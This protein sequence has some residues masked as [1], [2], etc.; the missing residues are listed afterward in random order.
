M[1]DSLTRAMLLVHQG[2]YREAE[3]YLRQA[4]QDNP[5]DPQIFFYLATCLLHDPQR[6]PEALDSI[7]ESLRLFPNCGPYHAQKANILV[8]LGRP[9]EGLQEVREA[10]AQDPNS[11]DSYVSESVALL[12]LGH[13]K[14]AE[15]AA[16]RALVLDPD[17]E[18][19]ADNLADAL[20]IQ[21]RFSESQQ[22][23][24]RLLSR[25]PEN[26]WT[27]A[28]AG[29][30]DLQ[31]GNRDA[32]ERHFLESLRLEP[33][34]AGAKEGLIN[35]FRSRSPLYR[36]Y[37]QYSFFMQRLSRRGRLF[38]IL[39][40]LFSIQVARTAASGTP[41][42][43]IGLLVVL[44]YLLVILWIWVAKAVSNLFLL[45]DRFAVH[46][47]DS[48]E[49][50]EAMVVGGGVILGIGLLGFGLSLKM[51]ALVLVGVTLL[52]ASFPM[53]LVFTN[54]SKLGRRLFIYLGA[55]VYIAGATSALLLTVPIENRETLAGAT[56]GAA[57]VLAAATT[58]L[59][60]VPALRRG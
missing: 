1:S 16:R 49:K 26:P 55:L 35:A 53:S 2:R 23:I 40:L 5:Q 29:W 44:L 57:M 31:Q 30:L 15:H 7:N 60:N 4:I 28:S 27:H 41:Y 51:M 39:G 11:P 10:R 25:N 20:R 17:H 38:L 43:W 9:K 18:A 46:A 50:T 36:G 52:A 48:S 8:L 19:A 12:V 45:F 33:E 13:P 24:A 58:W 3:R 56:V 59:G 42:G 6:R 14:E 37:L 34:H 32:A 21:G 22:Q 54:K 47:L